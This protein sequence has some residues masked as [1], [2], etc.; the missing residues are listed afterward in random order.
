MGLWE[1]S[2]IFSST[3][4]YQLMNYE[5]KHFKDAIGIKSNMMKAYGEDHL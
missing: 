5:F 4:I 3:F 1:Y 2:S